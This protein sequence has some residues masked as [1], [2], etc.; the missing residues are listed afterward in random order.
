MATGLSIDFLF[1]ISLH[2]T[3]EGDKFCPDKTKILLRKSISQESD[4][5]KYEDGKFPTR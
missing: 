4:W 5:R 2:V 3:R 1:W